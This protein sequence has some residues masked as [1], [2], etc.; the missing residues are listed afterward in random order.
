[1]KNFKKFKSKITCNMRVLVLLVCVSL[2]GMQSC[3]KKEKIAD[4]DYIVKIG[5]G[6]S[7]SLCT[8][9]LFIAAEKGFYTEE[10]LKYEMLKIDTSQI[11]QLLTTGVIDATNMLLASM[12]QPLVNGLDAKIPLAFHTGC[13]KV[14]AAPLSEIKTPADL[15]GKR[16]GVP[17]MGSPPTIII[18]RYLEALGIGT[19]LPNMEVEFIVFPKPELPLALDKGQIDAFGVDDPI[20]YM[21]AAAGKTVVI[22]TTTDPTMKDEFCC[23]LF[24]SSNLIKDH[25]A[26]SVKLTRALQKASLWLSQNPDECAQILSDKGYVAGDPVINGQVLATYDWHSSVSGA[27]TAL[28]NNLTDLQKL[29][30]VDSDVDIQSVTDRTFVALEGVPDSLK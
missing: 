17:G 24:T 27:K 22:D 10:G 8:A 1:M 12:I 28:L 16:I 9:P 3:S 29:K 2:I 5:Y 23:V 13:I 18:Q 30:L 4:D 7:A 6:S 14:L 11:P 19:V 26:S 15:K 25:P 21:T 20:G